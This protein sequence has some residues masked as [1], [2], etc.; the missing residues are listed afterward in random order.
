MLYRFGGHWVGDLGK[1]KRDRGV[2]GHACWNNIKLRMELL[3]VPAWV[4]GE[5]LA[6]SRIKVNLPG[7]DWVEVLTRLVDS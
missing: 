6:G 2:P 1:N 3:L 5:S 7:W 4:L